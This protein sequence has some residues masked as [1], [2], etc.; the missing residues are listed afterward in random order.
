MAG[1]PGLRFLELADTQVES[2]DA[3]LELSV[4]SHVGDGNLHYNVLVPPDVD[5]LEF[6]KRI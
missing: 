4:Y 3:G 5:R 2:F 6:T 1:A